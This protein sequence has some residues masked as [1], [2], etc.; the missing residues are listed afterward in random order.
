MHFFIIGMPG[1]NT[2]QFF[3]KLIRVYILFKA[4]FI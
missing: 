2:A 1:V 4:E 3:L